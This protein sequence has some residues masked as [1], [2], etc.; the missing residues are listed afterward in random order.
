MV[1]SLRYTCIGLLVGGALLV[2]CA[3]SARM[4]QSSPTLTPVATVLYLPPTVVQSTP[5]ATPKLVPTPTPTPKPKPYVPPPTATPRP[6]GP[7]PIGGIPNISGQLILVNLNQQWLWVYQDRHLVFNTPV[8]TG[9]PEL[10][11]PPGRYSIA[12]RYQ[13][14]TFISPWP[15]GSPY[16]YTPEFIHYA[17]YFLDYGYYIHDASWRKYFGPGTN[18]PHTNPDGTTETGSHGCVETSTAAAQWIY[19]NEKDGATIDI[20]GT[21]PGAPPP[22]P[23][24]APTAS[25]TNTPIPAPSPTATP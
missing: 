15:Y 22:S 25:P 18:V 9:M 3:S 10:A 2:G 6:T 14:I 1:R 7:A 16:Y 13:N 24:P 17:M 19:A 8:T 21:T 4:A 12:R 11:T 5:T 23:T 20:V